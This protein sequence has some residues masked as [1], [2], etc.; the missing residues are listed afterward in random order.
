M[1]LLTLCL[2]TAATWQLAGQ[3]VLFGVGT[4]GGTVFLPDRGHWL[5]SLLLGQGVAAFALFLY[6]VLV[7]PL[8]AHDGVGAVLSGLLI[9]VM[10]G[11]Y[12]RERSV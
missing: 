1:I 10:I 6:G 9:G 2:L 8:V 5:S 11:C 12:R 4:A 7:G 3:R